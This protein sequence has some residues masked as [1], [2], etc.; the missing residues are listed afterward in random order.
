MRKLSWDEE[1]Q[2]TGSTVTNEIFQW[3]FSFGGDFA[4][5]AL[6]TNYDPK[7]LALSDRKRVEA[8]YQISP[9]ASDDSQL[10]HEDSDSA[11]VRHVRHGTAVDVNN[12]IVVHDHVHD[13]C[14]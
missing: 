5:T 3:I 9:T 8:A 1:F 2:W 7:N 6:G 11:A 14:L 12:A 10:K 4:E 13:F